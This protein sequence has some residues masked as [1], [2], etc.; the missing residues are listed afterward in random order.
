M[1]LSFVSLTLKQKNLSIRNNDEKTDMI[2]IYEKC[3]KTLR[4]PFKLT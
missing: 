1:A 2:L 3:G 4:T